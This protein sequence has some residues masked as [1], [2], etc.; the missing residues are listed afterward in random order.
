MLCADMPVLQAIGFLVRVMQH[1]LSFRRQRQL[2]GSWNP[3]AQQRAAFNFSA[4]GFDRN[5]RA[6]EEAAGERFVLTHQTEQQMFRLNR[7]RAKLRC[8]VASE[9][10]YP[11]RLFR[12]AFEH[13]F[14]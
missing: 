9:K 13:S 10:N 2:D 3:L 11:S 5:L 6:W 14:N 7:G 12:V 8:F 1:T 4:N